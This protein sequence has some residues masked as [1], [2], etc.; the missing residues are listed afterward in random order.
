[1]STE[2]FMSMSEQEI[3]ALSRRRIRLGLLVALGFAI[4]LA[5]IAAND[6]MVQAGR[7]GS[8]PH[9]VFLGVIL[10]GGVVLVAALFGFVV[11]TRRSM[12]DPRLRRKLWDE[13]ASANHRQS[14]IVAYVAMLVVLVVLAVISMFGSLSAPWVVN[15][16]LITA[17]GVQAVAFAL[18]ERRGNG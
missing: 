7:A 9:L 11:L 14:M 18:L 17:F 1:M 5:G 10:L 4:V 3:E 2:R 16:M 13:L 15:G 8:T 12:R 6:A